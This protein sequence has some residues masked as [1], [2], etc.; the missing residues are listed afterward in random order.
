MIFFD[1]IHSRSRYFRGA[2]KTKRYGCRVNGLKMPDPPVGS[3]DSELLDYGCKEGE[4]L[5]EAI[6]VELGIV[7]REVAQGH[8]GSGWKALGRPERERIL[9]VLEMLGMGLDNLLELLET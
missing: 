7:E 5:V 8:E 4:A 9:T 3:E 6:Y 1:I 2:K